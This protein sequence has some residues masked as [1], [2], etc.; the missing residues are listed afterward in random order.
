MRKIIVPAVVPAIVLALVAIGAGPARAAGKSQLTLS[1]TAAAGHAAAVVLT[2]DPA[3]G[4][5][6]EAKRV[7]K[8]LAKVSGDPSRMKAAKVMCT[9]EF[10]PVTAEVK[11]KWR[12][13]TVTW[14]HTFGNACDLNR[15]TGVLFAF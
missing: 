4:V 6:P 9:L 5:H 12:G 13:K 8:A 1:Y 7:C 10:A 2:C 3:G 15:A 14:S 11:G